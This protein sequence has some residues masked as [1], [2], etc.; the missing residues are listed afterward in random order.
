MFQAGEGL[1]NRCGIYRRRAGISN[2][3]TLI[4]H[5]RWKDGATRET[6]VER[7]FRVYQK[8]Y[9][10]VTILTSQIVANYQRLAREA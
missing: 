8:Y 4:R 5:A 3:E 9:K 6:S 1:A 10:T 2:L 7:D